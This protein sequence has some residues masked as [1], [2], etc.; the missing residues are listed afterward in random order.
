MSEGY[1][2]LKIVIILLFLP[3]LIRQKFYCIMLLYYIL[4]IDVECET[5]S[6]NA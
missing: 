4:T 3:Q 2:Q 6:R 1:N 5:S